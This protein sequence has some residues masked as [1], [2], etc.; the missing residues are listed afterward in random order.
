MK[1]APL[2]ANEL[3]RLKA[4]DSYEILDTLPEEDFDDITRIASELCGTPIS[5]VSL[6]DPDRQ[7]FKSHHGLDATETPRNLAFVRMP[8]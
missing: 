4:L 6:I 7:W 1:S 3:T 2:P 5:L 8:F